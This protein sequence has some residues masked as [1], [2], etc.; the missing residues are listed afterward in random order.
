MLFSANMVNTLNQQNGRWYRIS[1]LFYYV[2]IVI[3]LLRN[4]H[5]I[6][7]KRDFL[8]KV[9]FISKLKIIVILFEN[10]FLWEYIHIKV[11]APG[12]QPT[13][14]ATDYWLQINFFSCYFTVE[15][16]LLKYLWGKEHFNINFKSKKTSLT[17]TENFHKRFHSIIFLLTIT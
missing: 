11:I 17:Y 13:I 1:L 14:S 6:T 15:D 5:R 16:F 4:H 12:W 9:L 10:S 2:F 8:Y 7:L 3:G